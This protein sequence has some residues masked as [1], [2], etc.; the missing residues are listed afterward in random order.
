L[1]NISFFEKS[2]GIYKP[3]IFGDVFLSKKVGEFI[4]LKYLENR[5]FPEKVGEFKDLKFLE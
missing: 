5:F 4:N 1:E 2:W 3:Q